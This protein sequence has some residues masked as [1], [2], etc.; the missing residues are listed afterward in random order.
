MSNSSHQALFPHGLSAGGKLLVYLLI[1]IVLITLDTRFHLLQPIRAAGQTGLLFIEESAQQPWLAWRNM[2]V[3]FTRQIQLEQDNQHF[4]Q[5]LVRWQFTQQQLLHLQQENQHLRALLALRTSYPLFSKA[6]DIVGVPRDPFQRT[7]TV[8]A[9]ARQG[10]HLGAAVIDEAGLIGQITQIYP[11]SSQVTLLTDKNQTISIQ[12]E[13]TGERAILYGDGSTDH[14]ELRYLPNNG[15]IH[16]GDRII[17][18]GLDGLYPAGLFV[19]T[20]QH[21][22]TNS[23][24]AFSTVICHTQGSVDRNRHV[25]ILAPSKPVQAINGS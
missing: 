18:S 13:R 3:F 10:I 22:D 23:G 9:G 8:D 6:A 17:T 11:F 14:A 5:A 25:L 21:I 2:E 24:L 4:R 16:I 1:S 20:V 15:D 19:A 12:I 7:F